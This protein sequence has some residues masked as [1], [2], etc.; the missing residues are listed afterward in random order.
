VRILVAVALAALA[1]ALGLE[2]A[3]AGIALRDDARR[4]AWM[5]YV[6]ASLATRVDRLDP[7]LPLPATL[8][9]VLARRALAAGAL[10]LVAAHVARLPA[11]RDR[12]ELS[13]AL[14]DRH[15]DVET[16]V[17]FFLEAGDLDDIERRVAA[18]A[19]SGR[20]DSA[21]RLQ[22][23]AIAAAER[24]PA[25]AGNLPE[26]YY[27]LGLLEQELA[28]R[29][30]DIGARGE[31]QERS[32]AAYRK[33]VELAPLEIRYLL[34]AANEA[35]NVGDLDAALGFFQRA[36]DSDPRNAEALAG[37]GD[38]AARRGQT[39]QA[40]DYLEQARR[41]NPDSPAVQ[42]LARQIGQSQSGQ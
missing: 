41:V 34:G 18:L 7:A 17:R 24:D 11:S 35:I 19:N 6:P 28:Y 12:A 21:L 29:I 33:A 36:R 15:G 3:L 5:R 25:Q 2:Q 14:A 30:P 4:P 8:R 16:A 9:L 10:D 1:L 27:Q 31:P 37:F 26:A 40:K 23:A 39:A 13:G 32:F 42:R 20:G 38:V 22:R